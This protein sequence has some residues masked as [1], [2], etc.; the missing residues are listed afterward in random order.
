MRL[1][2]KW[3]IA[4]LILWFPFNALAGQI[5]PGIIIT[6]ENYQEYLPELKKMTSPHSYF[7]LKDALEN[8][9]ITLP[10][11]EM[12]E[13]P[14][15]REYYKYTMK[16]KGTAKVGPNNE[17]IDWKAG[18]PFVDPQNG[19]ELAW[20]LDRR[21]TVVDQCSFY[22][23]LNLYREGILERQYRWH[24][25]NL[26][27]TGRV[28]VPPIHDLPNNTGGIR[29][30]ESFIMLA[31]FDIK[32]FSFIR[33]RYEDVFKGDEVYSYIP[34]IRRIR[35]LTGADVCDP[36]LGSDVIY[37]D[38]ESFRQKITPKMTFNMIKR[39]M[40]VPEYWLEYPPL[41]GC[42]YQLNWQ[43]RPVWVVEIFPHDPEY[44]YSKR[45][46]VMDRQRLT[47]NGYSSSTYDQ[48]GRFSRGQLMVP[49]MHGAPH[50]DEWGAVARYDNV[51]ARH[52]TQLDSDFTT[53]DFTINEKQFSFK[54]LLKSAR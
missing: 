17:L 16:H 19:A 51:I 39:E 4:L 54:Q 18:M 10:I 45:V 15:S 48:K 3:L 11:V 14:Q 44:I 30:K 29:M 8:G 25:W 36:M 37:D 28:R 22:A 52:F 49:S 24:Y 38:F 26:Y 20:N 33:T 47:G 21:Q 9:L 32:G 13:Y 43:I 27:Y 23:N 50:W 40:L 1:S 53:P 2:G 5:K 42:A 34:A 12:T 31:P 41:K 46:V 7:Y 35:R 6:Q